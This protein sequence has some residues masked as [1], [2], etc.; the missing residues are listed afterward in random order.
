MLAALRKRGLQPAGAADTHLDVLDGRDSSN[1]RHPRQSR[2]KIASD[3]LSPHVLAEI[4]ELG[5]L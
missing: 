2:F 4:L 1:P 5:E 3:D